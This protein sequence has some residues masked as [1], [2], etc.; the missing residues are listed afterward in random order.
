MLIPSDSHGYY[1]R[2]GKVW[3]VLVRT[4]SRIEWLSVLVMF[5]VYIHE[6]DV[7]PDAP[8]WKALPNGNMRV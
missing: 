1:P 5:D 8:T 4:F 7:S 6:L 2:R 3:R